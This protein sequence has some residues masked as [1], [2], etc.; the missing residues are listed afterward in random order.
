[1]IRALCLFSVLGVSA[2]VTPE[3]QQQQSY[4]SC[5]GY[6]F[7]P[8]TDA[9]AQCMQTAEISRKQQQQAAYANLQAI[10]QQYQYQPKTQNV[11]CSQMGRYT[12]C[13]GF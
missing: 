5:V 12:N 2:C 10:S 3:Q 1:M 13:T 8:G 6:G 7:E 9:M 4:Q 11:T